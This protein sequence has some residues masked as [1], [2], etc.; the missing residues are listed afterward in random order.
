MSFRPDHGG[1]ALVRLGDDANVGLSGPGRACM[2]YVLDGNV[3]LESAGRQEVLTA[4]DFVCLSRGGAHALTCRNP[5]QREYTNLLRNSEFNDEPA[6]LSFGSPCPVPSAVLI[7]GYFSLTRND[8]LWASSLLS[9]VVVLRAEKNVMVSLAPPSLIHNASTGLGASAFVSGLM[10][11]LLVQCIRAEINRLES[12]ISADFSALQS[13]KIVAAIR[14][15]ETEF[16]RSWTVE[17][18]ARLVG[19]SRSAFASEFKRVTGMTPFAKLTA[20]R[21]AEA[22]RMLTGDLPV[23]RIASAVG[24]Q[25]VAAFSRA[26]RKHYGES[27]AEHR[28]RINWKLRPAQGGGALGVILTCDQ[29]ERG[30]TSH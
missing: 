7:S 19:M 18:L 13:Y 2:H 22:Q 5:R 21:L 9:D 24:Y 20:A 10:R 8:G 6:I 23:G 16:S 3:I 15:L 26:F 25:S 30:N 27:A 4:G 17:S 1:F 11:V 28:R 12:V 14:A 29:Q